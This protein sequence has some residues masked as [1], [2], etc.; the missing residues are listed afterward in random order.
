MTSLSLM[1]IDFHLTYKSNVKM[2]MCFYVN[3][4]IDLNEWKI[5]LSSSDICTLKMK[6]WSKNEMKWIHIHNIYNSSS[7]LYASIDSSFTLSTAKNQ[8]QIDVKHVFLKNFNL[9]HS[10]WNDPTRPTQH[11]AVYQL[12]RIVIKT[13]LNLALS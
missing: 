4:N 12:L 7:V 11:V 2:R 1:R 8:L 6:L 9:H 10:I 13:K 5:E 3:K